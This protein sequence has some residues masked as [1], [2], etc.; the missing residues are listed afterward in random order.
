MKELE[1]ID[2]LQSKVKQARLVEKL[3]KQRY[4][5]DI[6]EQFEPI[7]KA[8]TESN[9]KLIEETK[10]NTKQLRIWRNQINVLKLKR[11]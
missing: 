5:N 11:H 2:D 4:Q 1:D 8:V 9:Q 10:S 6:K 7:I 3:G